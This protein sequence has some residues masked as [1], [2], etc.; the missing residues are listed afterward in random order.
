MRASMVVAVICACRLAA[1]APGDPLAALPERAEWAYAA[2][3][4]AKALERK[5]PLEAVRQALEEILT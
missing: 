4:A 3:A 2:S 1:A 5:I